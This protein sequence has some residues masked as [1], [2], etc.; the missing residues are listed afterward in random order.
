MI[1]KIRSSEISSSNIVNPSTK[2]ISPIPQGVQKAVPGTATSTVTT[3]PMVVHNHLFDP[4]RDHLGSK[5]ERRDMKRKL[6]VKDLFKKN[7]RTEGHHI[8]K[9]Q[10]KVT[11]EKDHPA[12]IIK[13]VPKGI[14]YNQFFFQNYEST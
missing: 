6:N 10:I 12:L 5:E 13:N 14:D 4:K 2:K 7:K 3:Q 8:E 9:P 11:K 1:S